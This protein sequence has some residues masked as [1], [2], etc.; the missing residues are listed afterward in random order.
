MDNVTVTISDLIVIRNVIDLASSRGAFRANELSTVG[1][2]FD[3]LQAFLTEVEEQAKAAEE[4][5]AEGAES[6][7]AGVDS[8]TGE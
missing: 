7:E 8:S 1:T 3:K 2:V 4:A 5:A 6:V